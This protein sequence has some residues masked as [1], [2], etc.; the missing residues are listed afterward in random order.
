VP[1]IAPNAKPEV[2]GPFIMQPEG[3]GRLFARAT[4]REG[5]Y[6]VHYEPFESPIANP[7]NPKIRGNPVARVFKGDME[8]FGDA[9]EFPYAAT[10]YRLTEHFHYWTKHSEINAS[11]QPEFFVEISEELAKEKSIANGGWVRVW[12]KRGSV[13][14]KVYVTKRIKPMICDG[15]TVHVVGIPLHWGFMGRARKGFGPNSLTPYVGDA[16]AETPE[17]KAFLVDIEPISAGPVS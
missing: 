3:T 15:K 11:L 13:K 6:P 2:V 16:N 1:D 17:F 9:K 14:A 8:Q 4:M 7:I 12:S 5:P 10:S